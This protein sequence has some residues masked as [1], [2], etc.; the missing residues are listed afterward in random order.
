VAIGWDD[1][2]SQS[3]RAEISPDHGKIIKKS[4]ANLDFDHE[5]A[6]SD[7][8]WTFSFDNYEASPDYLRIVDKL[9]RVDA[10]ISLGTSS[11]HAPTQI[12]ALSDGRLFVLE[13]D[14]K[15]AIVNSERTE[16]WTWFDLNFTRS[17]VT[18]LDDRPFAVK[19]SRSGP[20]VVAT[21][22]YGDGEVRRYILDLN[23]FSD[24]ADI[25]AKWFG[26]SASDRI[27]G[28]RGAD[29]LFGDGSSDHIEGGGG[30]DL[31]KGGAGNDT[32]NGGGGNDTLEGGSGKDNVDGGTGLDMVSYASARREIVYSL[33]IGDA[34]ETVI[35]I[36][37]VEG[38]ATHKNNLTGD[39]GANRLSGGSAADK[40]FG[41]A[42]DDTLAPRAGSDLVN[43]GS[44]IDTVSFADSDS[45]VYINLALRTAKLETSPFQTKLV[46]IENAIGSKSKANTIIGNSSDNLIAGSSKKDKLSGG[47]GNDVIK[48]DRGIDIIDG[49]KGYDVV[50]YS[51][52]RQGGVNVASV[53]DPSNQYAVIRR[54]EKIIGSQHDDEIEGTTGNNRIEGGSSSDTL[55]GGGGLDKLY[56]GEGHDRIF[57]DL[58]YDG[59][60][61]GITEGNDV[62][63]G[64]ADDDY[65]SG[66]GGRDRLF[67]GSGDDVIYGDAGADYIDG[68]SG[69]DTLAYGSNK[70]VVISLDGSPK[71]G[72]DA[73][74]DVF[75]NIEIILGGNGDD[76]ITGDEHANE[77][78]GGAGDDYLFGVDG[79]D[80]LSGG[81][82]DDVLEGGEG[83][84]SLS[85]GTGFD[86]IDYRREGAVSIS[87]SGS[88]A[89]GAG[90]GDFF[91]DFEGVYGSDRQADKISGDEYANY[92]G[93]FGGNDTLSGRGGIDDL[94]G[95]FGK[96]RMTGGRQEDHYIYGSAREG[97]DTI[98]DFSS[99]DFFGFV[100]DRFGFTEKDVALDSK[101]F[102]SSTT[103]KATRDNDRFIF[104]TDTDKLWFDKDGT[105]IAR[106]V[107]IATLENGFNLSAADIFL[108]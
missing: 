23:S 11:E 98:T 94:Y 83:E 67:G 47:E 46:S 15:A 71:P 3:L 28:G 55:E 73:K 4:K 84:D 8:Y 17:T 33:A 30:N 90:L 38:S 25:G 48:P 92:L 77:F 81:G 97:G 32:L 82:G 78:D 102:R 58:S 80:S 42:G 5:V 39:A 64:G 37:G 72:G 60:D 85:G 57:G 45:G 69:R 14:Y 108:I 19:L 53:V 56:G 49:G 66:G 40:L 61:R 101:Y 104:E 62:L 103:N 95:G 44:G 50:D 93:G 79:N 75:K 2:S 1:T 36:E 74:G 76:S 10:R 31:L 41:L 105:D 34:L 88:Y 26:G 43:G 63:Y 22:T 99:S 87:L 9:G 89:D 16:I 21:V 96:D 35:N 91:L 13:G 6:G 107:L 70:A 24:S 54:V 100:A 27:S 12:V 29:K 18:S 20:D 52:V 86:I 59:N 7:L 106:A 65:L 68:G 51:G